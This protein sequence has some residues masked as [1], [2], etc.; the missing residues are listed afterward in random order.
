MPLSLDSAE[1]ES[2]QKLFANIR[3]QSDLRMRTCDVCNRL[4]YA[5]VYGGCHKGVDFARIAETNQNHRRNP[6]YP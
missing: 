4:A 1:S 2:R 5:C 3:R 6:Q